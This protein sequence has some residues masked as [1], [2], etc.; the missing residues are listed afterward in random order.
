MYRRDLQR[1]ATEL[2]GGSPDELIWVVAVSGNY[3][4]LPSFGCCSV[5]SD[6]P[7]HNTWGLA[8]DVDAPGPPVANEFAVSYHGDWPPSSMI[9][10]I[11]PW[12]ESGQAVTAMQISSIFAAG[13][14]RR[15]TSRSAIAG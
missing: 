1:A 12:A 2:S 13:S 5:P 15:R 14:K 7:G 9:C 3:G 4:I 10:R 8:I 11:L 6:Y